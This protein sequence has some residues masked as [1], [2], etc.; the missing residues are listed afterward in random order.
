[1]QNLWA[2]MS[3]ADWHRSQIRYE[4]VSILILLYTS[5]PSP[6]IW[7]NLDWSHPRSFK[8]RSILVSSAYVHSQLR[9]VGGGDAFW[10]PVTGSVLYVFSSFSVFVL[11]S[12]VPFFSD[13]SKMLTGQRQRHYATRGL[14]FN[15]TESLFLLTFDFWALRC[16]TWGHSPDLI[17]LRS[18]K[19]W[20]SQSITFITLINHFCPGWSC[21][22]ADL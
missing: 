11:R 4:C 21:F 12:F 15:S 13:F 3:V 20:A 22:V 2:D 1:M 10:T 14:H 19:V 16:V 9:C 6:H 7:Q 8:R 5:F 18:F 17:T